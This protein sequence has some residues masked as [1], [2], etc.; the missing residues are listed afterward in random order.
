MALDLTISWF[1]NAVHAAMMWLQQK[2]LILN[3]LWQSL[4]QCQLPGST[5]TEPIIVLTDTEIT[6]VW[7]LYDADHQ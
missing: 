3:G 6:A 1:A 5:H 7:I 4:A 2:L